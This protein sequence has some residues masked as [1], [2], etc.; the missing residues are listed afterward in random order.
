MHRFG[1]DISDIQ[2]DVL[3]LLKVKRALELFKSG[4]NAKDEN[5]N[6]EGGESQALK[7]NKNQFD[8]KWAT[9][10]R[11]YAR[12]TEKLSE[13]K[14]HTLLSLAKNSTLADSADR[15][16]NKA[17][18][19]PTEDEELLMAARGEI[20]ESDS[21]AEDEDEVSQEAESAGGEDE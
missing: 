15:E 16:A 20:P 11:L 3:T 10:A 18:I 1:K 8:Q 12:S 19:G 5:D 7:R 4:E 21:E 14:W 9:A 2:S 17:A 6:A 13:K